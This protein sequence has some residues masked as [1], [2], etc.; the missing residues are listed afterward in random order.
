MITPI[1]YIVGKIGI[2]GLNAYDYSTL[3]SAGKSL[4]FVIGG[5]LLLNSGFKDPQLQV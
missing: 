3:F 5:L 4:P 2:D 1:V